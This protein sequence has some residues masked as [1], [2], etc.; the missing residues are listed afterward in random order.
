MQGTLE[1]DDVSPISGTKSLRYTQAAGSL[2][3]YFASEIIDIDLKQQNNSS[4]LTLYYT[5]DGDGGDIELI[6]YDATNSTVLSINQTI[7]ESISASR[8]YVTV[9]IPST[10]TQIRWG[11]QVLVENIGAELIVDDVEISVVPKIPLLQA[12]SF[13][14]V[15]SESPCFIKTGAQSLSVKAGTSVAV[16]GVLVQFSIDTSVILPTLTPGTDYAIYVC[17]DESIRAS[18]N[19]TAPSGYNTTNSRKIG[20]FHYGL[21][22]PTETVA[23]GSLLCHLWKWYD[24]DSS[25]RR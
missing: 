22:S 10:C 13:H 24:L 12:E 18:D 1:I 7:Q 2:N 9:E 6:V 19:F 5:Y 21:V 4:T 25:R 16:D 17:S 23:G 3:D 14:K 20:G 15:D 11:A 8:R